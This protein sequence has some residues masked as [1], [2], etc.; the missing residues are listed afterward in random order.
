MESRDL[1]QNIRVFRNVEESWFG[2]WKC[3]LP[4][5]LVHSS[6]LDKVL[7]KL[8]DNLRSCNFEVNE[9]LLRIILSSASFVADLG[10][11]VSQLL[12]HGGWLGFG[13]CCGRTKGRVLFPSSGSDEEETFD[14][15]AS[16]QLILDALSELGQPEAPREPFIL[17]LDIDVQVSV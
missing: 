2:P 8:T 17:V 7:K 3:L 4:G 1:K 13:D 11:C 5:D 10:A 14:V 6:S 9:S 16:S 12:S 15:D